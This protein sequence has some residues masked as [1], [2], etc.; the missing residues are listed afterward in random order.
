MAQARP[1]VVLGVR[2]P[3]QR[4]GGG[5]A[6]E[7]RHLTRPRREWGKRKGKAEEDEGK[8]G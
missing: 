6:E 7:R 8:M 5:V 3:E 2:D 4:M 1:D